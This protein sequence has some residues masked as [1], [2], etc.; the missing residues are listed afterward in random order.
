[1]VTLKASLWRFL[2]RTPRLS[3]FKRAA[4]RAKTSQMPLM[5]SS[6][7]AQRLASNQGKVCS[8]ANLALTKTVSTVVKLLESCLN[9][10]RTN[11]QLLVHEDRMSALVIWTAMGQAVLASALQNYL[12]LEVQ[13]AL[14]ATTQL[15]KIHKPSVITKEAELDNVDC[16]V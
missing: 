13:E 7:Q 10:Y 1:M 15:W 12:T 14:L 5:T 3:A 11:Q 6:N 8:L 4:L 9:S 16:Q 2:H